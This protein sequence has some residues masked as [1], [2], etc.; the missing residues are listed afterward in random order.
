MNKNYNKPYGVYKIVNLITNDFYIG[1]TI[2]YF[3]KRWQKHQSDFKHN[4]INNTI[5]KNAFNK[6]GFENF[7]MIPIYTFINRRNSKTEKKIVTF[8]EEKLINRLKPKY[9]I[10]QKPTRGGCPN[11]NKKLSEEWKNKIKEKSKLYRHSEKTLKIVSDNNK[12]NKSVYE[13]KT[14]NN[15]FK[16]TAKEC[17]NFLK[18]NITM[19]YYYSNNKHSENKE[20]I[21]NKL[22]SQKKKITLVKESFKKTF[23]SYGEC[24]RF[25]NMWRGFTSTQV[26]KKRKTILNYNY[27]IEDIV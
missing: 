1:S 24:D 5:L 26:V 15:V 4:K 25:L 13:V 2:E 23:D 10:C 21:V 16:G 12:E 9:N 19:I 20:F 14:L 18:V 17:A 22:K 27:I 3:D 8:L 7:K 6:Y 11:L